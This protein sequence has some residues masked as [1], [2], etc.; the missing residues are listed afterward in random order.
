[1]TIYQERSDQLT[2]LSKSIVPFIFKFV[3]TIISKIYLFYTLS[4]L[5]TIIFPKSA[6]ISRIIAIATSM[7]FK[8]YII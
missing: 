4:P 2:T 5:F 7:I 3:F 1:M 8:F 6:I